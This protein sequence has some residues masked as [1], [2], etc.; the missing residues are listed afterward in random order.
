MCFPYWSVIPFLALLVAIAVLPM[1][2]PRW[3]NNNA[4]KI[5]VSVAA[6]LPVLAV[7][8]RCNPALLQHSLLDY[9]SFVTLMGALFVISSGIYIRGEFAG[10][11][12]ENTLFLAT[13]ALLSNVIG[14]TGASILL[15]RPYMRANHARQHKTHLMVFFIFIV[16]NI[17]GLLIPL[18]NPPFLGFLRGVPFLWT[19]RLWPQWALA[20]AILLAVFVIFDRHV[21]RQEEIATHG[22]VD[23]DILPRRALEV[24]GAVNIFYLFGVMAAAILSGYF[25]WPRGIQEAIIFAMIL[26]SWFTTP[27]AVHEAN[28]FS[29]HPIAEVAALFL[30]IFVTMIPTLEIL[31]ARAHTLNITQP[32]QFFWLSGGLSSFLDNAPTYLTFASLA[33]GLSG[34]GAQDFRIL[35]DS[36]TG[37]A[38]L[39][40]ISCGAVFMGANTYVG[41]GPN[42]MVK[43][44]AEHHGMKMPTFFGY[45][46]YAFAILIPLFIIE[47]AVFFWS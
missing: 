42:F 6:S 40:A 19:L 11:P 21:F 7:V 32:W 22:Q 29:L 35:L 46:L 13:G 1:A 26:L 44:I 36:R 28:H 30:G 25:G 12:F 18:G 16:S 39:A 23:E 27:R 20:I 45:M 10:T 37:S 24:R 2:A 17:G 4:N 8:L 9:F 3:W 47:T 34:G 38:L 5:I 41:N 14:S 33:S 43:S 15:V 31:N